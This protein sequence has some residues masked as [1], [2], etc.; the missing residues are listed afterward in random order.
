MRRLNAWLLPVGL[1]GLV[2]ILPS[3]AGLEPGAWRY[4]ALFVFVIAAL[5]TEPLPGAAI[6]ILGVSLGA[7]LDLVKPTAAESVR[8]AL[9]G[10]SNEVV[11]LIFSATTFALGYEVTGLGRRV[12][13]TLVSTLG[14]RTIG[15]GYAV[16][17]SDLVLAPFMPSNTARSVGTIYPVVRNI[18]P[19]YGS[20]PTE[21]PRA[22][23]AY[24]FW[25]AF[26]TTCLTSSMFVT[27]QAPNLLATEMARTIASVDVTWTSWMMGFLPVGLLLFV[28]TPLVT[29]IVYPPTIT[30]ASDVA[31]WAA[32]QLRQMGPVSRREIAMAVLAA[33]ALLGWIFGSAWVSA[34]TVALLVV[35]VMLLAGVVSWNDVLSN[36][37]G[38]NVLI[39]FATLLTMANGLGEVGFISWFAH[40]SASRLS[41]VPEMIAAIGIVSLFFLIHYLFASTSAHTAAVLPAFLAA[42]VAFGT[43]RVTPAVVLMLLYTV[44]IMGVLTPY[45]TGPAPVWY[46]AGYISTREFWTL[47]VVFGL[48]YLGG[49]LLVGF[50]IAL[51][52]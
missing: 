17:L 1:A 29:Y 27:S 44:G 47:G 32:T 28:L 36:T 39:W 45:G 42:V 51:R 23:G 15:L 48:L 31:G 2:L 46:H 49:L 5:V 30:N 33:L 14:K 43:D 22:I 41:T 20:S 4:L 34:V 21:N 16:A 40:L 37:P 12:A 8:W 6:G 52:R 10:F 11:W 13:L 3:P 7:A 35:S 26:A 9:S 25:I 50:P 18:P 19:L 38:W 24:L